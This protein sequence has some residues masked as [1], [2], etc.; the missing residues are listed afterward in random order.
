MEAFH[1]GE[2]IAELHLAAE[3]E[4]L[5]AEAIPELRFGKNYRIVAF[6][7]D[8]EEAREAETRRA[9]EVL[10]TPYRSKLERDL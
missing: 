4:M 7:P 10:A 9:E 6:A 2:I 3:I 1:T 5:G 8:I